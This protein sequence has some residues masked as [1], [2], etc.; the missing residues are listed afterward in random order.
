MPLNDADVIEQGRIWATRA[1]ALAQYLVSL[2]DAWIEEM[3]AE[4]LDPADAEEHVRECL[5]PT[6]WAAV[7][8]A[9]ARAE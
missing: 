7:K 8:E 1:P 6:I 5:P 9:V 4:G 3:V 2:G